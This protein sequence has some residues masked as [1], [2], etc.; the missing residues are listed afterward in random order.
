MG[1]EIIVEDTTFIVKAIPAKI[2]LKL[3]RKF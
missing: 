2:H 1:R 3:W